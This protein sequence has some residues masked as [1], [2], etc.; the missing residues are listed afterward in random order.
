MKNNEKITVV[1]RLVRTPKEKERNLVITRDV[2]R[3]RG[4]TGEENPPIIISVPRAILNAVNMKKGDE[5][6][7]YTDGVRVYLEK[8]QAPEI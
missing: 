7:I 6:W 5:V 8:L 4:A 3:V 1:Q 2:V